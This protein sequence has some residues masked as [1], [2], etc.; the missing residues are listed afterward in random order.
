VTSVTSVGADEAY[1]NGMDDTKPGPGAFGHIVLAT[2]FSPASS[3]ALLLAGKAAKLFK[4]RLTMLHVF[5]Y[6]I[7]HGYPVRVRWMVEMLRNDVREKM[8]EAGRR[9]GELG[10]QAETVMIEDGFPSEEIT[11]YVGLCKN[12]LV[13]VGTHAVGGMDRFLLGSTAEQVLREALCPVVTTGPNVRATG[14]LDAC[15][16]RVLYPTDCGEASLKAVPTV[17]LI[18]RFLPGALRILQVATEQE[19]DGL[20]DSER[21]APVREALESSEW[22]SSPAPP[23]FVRVHGTE[24]SQA[25]VNEAELYP[26]DLIVLGV[27][28]AS[29]LASHLGPKLAFHVIA[30]APCPVLTFAS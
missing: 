2:D 9:L 8:N 24:I 14:A 11:A 13:F 7:H 17:A 18:R 27:H 19:R 10:V 20:S 28:R 6:P 1:L 15:F 21:F 3:A 16:S 23:E 12:P 26:A 25:I 5:Q 22:N 29:A 30:S 4:A